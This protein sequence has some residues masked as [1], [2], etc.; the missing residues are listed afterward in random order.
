MKLFKRL[1]LTI[2]IIVIILLTFSSSAMAWT[3]TKEVN[4]DAIYRTGAFGYN[5]A[6]VFYINDTGTTFGAYEAQGDGPV[7]FSSMDSFI[8]S[9]TYFGPYYRSTVDT[10]TER[11]SI[12]QTCKDLANNATLGYT[13]SDC[14]IPENNPGSYISPDEISELRCDGVVEYSYEWNNFWVWGRSNTGTSSGTPI[15]HDISYYYYYSEHN[16]LGKDQPWIELSPYVQ[17]G[18]AGTAWTLL[19]KR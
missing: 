13:W 8:G 5:H 17:R 19:R 15:H 2:A 3:R 12:I 18:A 9:E 11:N 7:V 1:K 10:S 6:G 16:N 14:L 4:A